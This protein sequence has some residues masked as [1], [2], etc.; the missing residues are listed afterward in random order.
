[1]TLLERL[2]RR[3]KAFVF[4]FLGLALA[5]AFSATHLPV[6]L[7]PQVSFPRIVISIDAGDRPADT[8]L[9]NVTIPI[10]EALRAVPGVKNLRSKT[11]R[12]SAEVSVDFEWG[13]E[14]TPA[15]LL[16]QS[17]MSQIAPDLP[18]ATRFFVRRMDPTVFPVVAI[19]LVSD[20]E[21][22]TTLRE[23]AYFELRPRLLAIDGVARVGIIG[24]AR[25]ELQVRVD[26]DVLDA[27]GLTISDVANAVGDWSTI[28][29]LG[30]IEDFYTLNLVVTAPQVTD[31]ATLGS[32]TIR[33]TDLSEVRLRDVATIQSAPE[34]TWTRVTADGREGV[35]VQVYQQPGGDTVAIS[36]DVARAVGATQQRLPGGDTLSVWYDQSDLIKASA[37]SVRDAV[38]IG[39]VLAGLVLLFFLRS[40]ELT[41][42]AILVVPS[43][44][45]STCL[46][47]LVLGQSLNIMTLG[48]MAAAVGL[49]IDDAIVVVEHIMSRLRGE[50][51]EPVAEH[52]SRVLRAAGEF[53][54]PLLGASL[55]TIII[56][57]PPV[58]LTGVT[59]EFFKALSLTMAMS[60]I[61]SFLVSYLAIPILSGRLLNAKDAEREDSGPIFGLVSGLFSTILRALFRLHWVA[62]ILCVAWIALGYQAFRGLPSGFMPQMDEGGFVL[63]YVA[64]PGTSLTE[65]DRLVRKVEAILQSTPEVSTY[66]RRTGVQLGGG[67]TEANEG[68]FF[69]RL[70]PAPR[71]GIE[72]IMAEVRG[73]IQNEVPGLSAEL[74]QLMEDLIG[75]LSAVPQPIEVK[76]TSVDPQVLEAEAVR[77]ATILEGI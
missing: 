28:E 13:H 67:L 4:T 59:G 40:L 21:A 3:S 34:P 77:V 9:A 11:S 25:E 2:S 26:P 22:T 51:D 56:H 49:I 46:L 71:R 43:V 8:M 31:A 64:A 54:R 48:G 30:R 61:L 62:P 72:D 63:D 15:L 19:S 39:T 6:A 68:D 33:T 75:D 18:S 58:F 20:H 45:A 36:A 24:G 66:S 47:L 16:V 73:R 10:E 14:M 12:G 55:A 5:G 70:V 23:R 60:L 38:I 76:L 27:A 42:I 7:F 52:R 29:A 57:V 53:T 37:A 1:M 41:L 35:L 32:L 65:T 74:L 69:V 50:R 44:L 17:A